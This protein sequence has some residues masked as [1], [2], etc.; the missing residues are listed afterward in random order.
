MNMFFKKNNLKRYITIN[1]EALPDF[2]LSKNVYPIQ[3][4]IQM[5]F[6][7]DR[8]SQEFRENYHQILRDMYQFPYLYVAL[9]MQGYDK[10]LNV[11]KPLISTKDQG[12]PTIYLFT[13]Y[14][15]AEVWCKHY[16]HY[17]QEGYLLGI[18]YKDEMD[19]QSIYRIASMM[20]VERIMLNEGDRYLNVALQDMLSVNEVLMIVRKQLLAEEL[21][22][23]E[24]DISFANCR[25]IERT[26]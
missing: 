1:V 7:Y 26:K 14:A 10:K 13:S 19:F 2:T 11:S 3:E 18:L 25:L 12:I 22:K 21:Q 9:S 4:K 15:I 6:S 20:Q 23:P 24:N 5:L 16:Q 8:S 17:N